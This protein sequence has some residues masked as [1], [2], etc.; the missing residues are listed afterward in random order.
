M[1]RARRRRAARRRTPAR[2]AALAVAVICI[3]GGL[4]TSA[5]GAPS[6]PAGAS[7]TAL[8]G[9]AARAADGS[10]SSTVAL[11]SLPAAAPASPRSTSSTGPGALTLLEAS[12]RGALPAP[13]VAPSVGA[14]KSQ[15]ATGSTVGAPS[16]TGLPYGSPEAVA[17]AAVA[18]A[19][20]AADQTTSLRA[21]NGV[22]IAADPTL[23]L[24]PL[25]PVPIGVPDF[26]IQTFAIPPFLIPI[27]Q[28]AAVEYE[29]P[30]QVLAAINEI[31][32]DYG[33]NLSVSTAGAEGWMQILPQTWKQYGVDAN[34]DGVKDPYNP[35]DAI[36]AAARFL[37]AAGASQSLPGAI[38]AYND[39]SWYADSVTLRAKLI[40]GLPSDFLSSITG[41]TDGLFPVQAVARY[42]DD[43]A[44]AATAPAAAARPST[45]PGAAAESSMAIKIY[46]KAGSPAIAVHDGVVTALGESAALGRYVELRDAYGNTYTYSQLK[47]L[48]ALYA[49]PLPQTASTA[50][51]NHGLALPADP[52]PL[53]T[54]T[55]GHQGA[56]VAVVPAP[57]T[58]ARPAA[59]GRL[60]VA[61]VAGVQRLVALAA[62]AV[63]GAAAR[64]FD[65][66]GY[67]TESY[68]LKPDD[69]DLRPLATG[70]HVV[71]GAILGRIGVMA[72]GQAPHLEFQ[73][74]P[75]GLGSPS[76]DPKPILDGWKL[77]EA[78]ATYRAARL[79]PFFGPAAVSPPVGQ[80][81]LESKPALQQ[82]VLAD[83]SITISACARRTIGAGQIDQRALARVEFL[84]LSGAKPIVTALGCSDATASAASVRP[85]GAGSATGLVVLGGVTTD[86]L[87]PQLLSL[88]GSTASLSVRAP[89]VTAS[90]AAAVAAPTAQQAVPAGAA[91]QPAAAQPAAPALT[92]AQWTA[93][94]KRLDQI[95]NPHVAKLPSSAAIPVAR[96][97]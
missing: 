83:Q 43:V 12:G 55:A 88:Q 91:A 1:S 20:N 70:A 14:A 31:E 85:G 62:R 77:L 13:A 71:A 48:N 65:L 9:D 73:I 64:P 26:F 69:V 17:A 59:I 94:V 29:V 19:A 47:T 81:M 96:G 46:A 22:P 41:L 82:Q 35:V 58:A 3:S 68:G 11:P 75:A 78:T 76:I 67:L 23:S 33:R 54:A 18:A 5:D 79:N 66:S 40:G 57:V 51:I 89:T 74:R 32:T 16:S 15:A 90:P 27:Y 30:W 7:P 97:H 86:P 28:A 25:G 39:A 50:Q 8:I 56:A 34:G 93:I 44:E 87:L 38:L 37:H 63:A 10:Q 45:T 60:T 21:A 80:I 95:G 53:T 2:Q 92:P 52:A 42:A 24:V 36:F 84:S 4:P 6:P 72:P 61:G 49:S